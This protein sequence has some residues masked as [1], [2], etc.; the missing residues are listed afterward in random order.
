MA[1]TNP[2]TA[3]HFPGSPHS[4]EQTSPLRC[5]PPIRE[6]QARPPVR[7]SAACWRYSRSQVTCS[8][9]V[10][11]GT[12]WIR[13]SGR[14]SAIRHRLVAPPQRCSS[15][16]ASPISRSTPSPATAP[17]P[18]E[19]T[20]SRS[21]RSLHSRTRCSSRARRTS[22]GAAWRTAVP[23]ATPPM[24]RPARPEKFSPPSTPSTVPS[25][26]AG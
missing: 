5:V 18:R 23:G 4:P 17:Y 26:R 16:R 13:A 14:M 22:G 19:P 20:I 24:L 11:I 12:I 1:F 7:Y 3:S 21:R 9:S 6:I 25:D 8:R 2:P 10:S 15:A